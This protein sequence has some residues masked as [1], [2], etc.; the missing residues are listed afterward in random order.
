MLRFL[1]FKN[2][3]SLTPLTISGLILSSSFLG[4][5]L[6]LGLSSS[7]LVASTIGSI[8]LALLIALGVLTIIST[9][10]IK[11]QLTPEIYLSTTRPEQTITSGESVTLNCKLPSLKLLPLTRLKL[12]L[13]LDDPEIATGRHE[14]SG[15]SRQAVTLSQDV[16]FTHRGRWKVMAVRFSIQDAFGLWN[17]NVTKKIAPIDINV[18]P[19]ARDTSSLDII[20]SVYT[21]GDTIPMGEKRAGD[22]YDL[23][24]YSPSDGVSKIAWKI[25]A[26]RGELITRQPER[27]VRPEGKAII[28]CLAATQDDQICS[29]AMA[30]MRLLE[31][32]E[33]EIIFGCEGATLGKTAQGSR[34]ALELMISAARKTSPTISQD[35]IEEFNFFLKS[36]TQLFAGEVANII[37]FIGESRLNNTQAAET[38]ASLIRR[39][40]DNALTPVVIL[41]D[42]NILEQ[43][44]NTKIDPLTWAKRWIITSKQKPQR[45]PAG[46]PELLATSAKNNWNVLT[47]P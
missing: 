4:L 33:I 44:I 40:N 34:A 5:L 3:F 31:S 2:N 30:Y 7:D 39:V 24:S 20:S 13:I 14:L 36:Q 15:S 18:E 46:L 22:Y 11:K 37:L 23:K 9:L 26:R 8:F 10:S 12:S 25:F 16:I 47:C 38:V 19:P 17:L 21:T 41:R 29:E 32:L 45:I 6:G 42:P 35:L 27:E 1:S 43:F 28:F